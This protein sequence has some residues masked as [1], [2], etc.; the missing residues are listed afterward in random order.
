MSAASASSP[1]ASSGR[2]PSRNGVGGL[3]AALALAAQH[4]HL[5]AAAL[6]GG[7]LELGEHEAQRADAI[8]LAGLHRA[9]DVG[10]HLI[11]D[12]QRT[13]DSPA[14]ARNCRQRIPSP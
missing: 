4:R 12:A 14:V 13:Q 8:L 9:G 7:L 1:S 3:E 11:G 2:P 10:P 6:L 5:V